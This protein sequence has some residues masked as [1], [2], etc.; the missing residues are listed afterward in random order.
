M[1]ESIEEEIIVFLGNQERNERRLEDEERVMAFIDDL[2]RWSALKGCIE[3]S[4]RAPMIRYLDSVIL[5]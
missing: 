1:S 2:L 4:F 5:E 3:K